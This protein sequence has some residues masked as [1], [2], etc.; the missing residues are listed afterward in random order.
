MLTVYLKGGAVAEIKQGE[1]L[2]RGKVPLFGE[3]D[4]AILVLDKGGKS[5]AAFLVTEIVGF[6]EPVPGVP[7][8][9][10]VGGTR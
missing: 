4:A 8:E 3:D 5:L 7:F 6:T 9:A 1:K 2:I 10:A